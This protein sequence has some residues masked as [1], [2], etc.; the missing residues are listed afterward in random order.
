MRTELNVLIKKQAADKIRKGFP[1]IEQTA[2][3][4]AL[5]KVDEGA[6]LHLFDESE[7]YLGK[8]Y[9]GKQNKGIGWVLTKDQHM[10]LETTFFNSHLKKAIEHRSEFL[11]S[12]HTTAFRL[13]NGEGDGIGGLTIDCYE[14]YYVFTWYSEGIYSFRDDIYEAFQQI[15]NF[16]GI[17]EKK[18]FAKAGQYVEDDDFV[19]GERGEFPLLVKENDVKFAVYLNDGPMTGVFLDQKD[20]RKRIKEHYSKG[21]S[22]L[23]TFSYT[24]AFSV[25]AALG[26]ARKTT[27][28]DLAKR[29]LPKTIEQFSINGVDYEAQ[30]IVVMDV[31]QYFKF[32]KKKG[33]RFDL[34]ILDP[35]SF[36]R[37]K[38]HTFS[39][40]KDYTGL[41]E[42]AIAITEKEGVIVA[43]TNC[44]TFSMSKF[45]MFI[46]E[47]CK[48]QGKQ[49]E[50]VEQYSL[51]KDFKT[52]QSFGPGDYLKV[53]FIKLKK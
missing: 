45:H 47:A 40:A 31:F 34:V 43:S 12:E 16:K 18:R 33:K 14:D 20:V 23:N 4:R 44:S 38:K 15:I 32:A 27:S 53:V 13:F 11:T 8:G 28:V 36:A 48:R 24:G 49:Y 42:E 19:Q 17:Y 39:A 26:G 2:L 21:K 46:K 29:S 25:A 41:L 50:I 37:S 30:D 6:I 1:L 22:V 51:P 5:P 7:R 35:P 3:V 9:Y 10:K 52:T